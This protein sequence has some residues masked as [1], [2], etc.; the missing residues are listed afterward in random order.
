[1][2]KCES[3]GDTMNIYLIGFMGV[4]KS[5]V[6][7]L[8]SKRLDYELIDTDH[9][10]ELEEGM[11]VSEIF[12]L[13]G[14]EYFRGL[15]AYLIHKIAGQDRTVVSCGGGIIKSEDNIKAMLGSGYVILLEASPEVIYDRLKDDNTRPLLQKNP[16]LE[17]VRKLMKEREEFYNKAYTYKVDANRAPEQVAED[18]INIVGEFH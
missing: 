14:E 4:G 6:A 10:I 16:G 8:L 1:M 12:K 13:E 7:R 9:E 11:P 2:C 5:T 3:K 15:E 18:I 17:G